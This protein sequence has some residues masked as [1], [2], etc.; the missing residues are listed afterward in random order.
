MSKIIIGI[1]GLGNKT[2]AETLKKWWEA[3]L[4]EGLRNSGTSDLEFSFELAYWAHLLHPTPLN[5]SVT[6]KNDPLYVEDP[7]IPGNNQETMEPSG[8]FRQK[9][10]SYLGNQL[11]GMFLNDDLTINFSSISDFIIKHFFSDLA[12]YY[13]TSHNG[14]D[15]LNLQKKQEI[16]KV[17]RTL[18]LEHRKKEIF[19]IGHS[20][21]SIIAYDVLRELE[22]ELQITTLLTIGCPLGL[23]I[24]RSKI[25]AEHSETDNP[26]ERLKTPEA[27]GESW[28]N[29]SDLRDKIALYHRLGDDFQSNSK[30]IQ[31]IDQTVMNTYQKATGD[32]NPHKAYG[33]LRTPELAQILRE[34]LEKPPT[35]FYSRFREKIKV[36]LRRIRFFN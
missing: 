30:G 5:A 27:V 6:D 34:F 9:L 25:A 10:M 13:Q 19:L 17:L 32:K 28:Y 31:V 35:R 21:G 3:S 22:Q 7:Y 20:M 24:I 14:Q 8:T 4:S 12:A 23:P 36:G 29:L 18:L 2:D 16:R 33:Y 11:E 15:V 1:H 26:K